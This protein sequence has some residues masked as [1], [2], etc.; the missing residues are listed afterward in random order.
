MMSN[1]VHQSGTV[2]PAVLLA[3]AVAG[4]LALALVQRAIDSTHLARETRAHL[5]LRM[6]ADSGVEEVW[7]RFQAQ[8]NNPAHP[9]FHQLR[10]LPAAGPVALPEILPQRLVT[11]LRQL[12]FDSPVRLLPVRLAVT[13]LV[14]LSGDAVERAGT[15]QLQLGLTTTEARQTVTERVRMQRS[16]KVGRVAI[17]RMGAPLDHFSLL[18]NEAEMDTLPSYVRFFTSRD[19]SRPV[20][21]PYFPASPTACARSA[22]EYVHFGVIQTV[23]GLYPVPA[24]ARDSMAEAVRAAQPESMRKRAHFLFHSALELERFL[25]GWNAKAIN[26][27]LHLQASTEDPVP[28][29]FPAPG[30]HGRLLISSEGPLVLGPIQLRDPRRD[31]I[32]IQAPAIYVTGSPVEAAL[33][34]AGPDAAGVY[35]GSSRNNSPAA[36]RVLGPV[37][38]QHYLRRFGTVGARTLGQTEIGANAS[39]GCGEERDDPDLDYQVIL[40]PYP[41][42]LEHSRL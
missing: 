24:S 36:F 17:P 33:M 6:L 12:V 10:A 31:A 28:L 23:P 14:S 40:S 13:S 3:T 26:G 1:R 25:R 38:S 7:L 2:L 19:R 20:P 30:L 22:G 18:L 29:S 37:F 34:S 27:I 5:T 16:F 11:E 32:T 39:L 41:V 15:I 8:A 4:T 9:L 21:P 35:F 42:G